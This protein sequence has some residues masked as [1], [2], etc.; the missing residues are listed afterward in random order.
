MI[1]AL[2]LACTLAHAQESDDARARELYDN[3][4]VLYEEGRYEDAVAAFEEA[5]KLSRRPA[6]LFNIA[7]ALERLGRYEE[8]LDVLSRYRAYAPADERETLD[9]RISNLERRIAEAKEAAATAP[10]AVPPPVAT[11]TP[12][13]PVTPLPASSPTLFRPVPLAIAG[14]GVAALGVGAGLGG[15]TLAAHDEAAAG[16]APDHGDVLRCSAAA[17]DAL[18]RETGTAAA[19]DVLMLAGV[20]GIGG[21]L[22]LGLWGEGGPLS[23]G[24]GYVALSG[25]F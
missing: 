10:A 7:N 4:A 11:V 20:L 2:L 1:T 13:A 3:G 6:L 25:Q 23:V 16:C 24:P 18:T 21:G 8:A 14:V 17:T 9:R 12:T 5:Y 19:A 22:A 15:L